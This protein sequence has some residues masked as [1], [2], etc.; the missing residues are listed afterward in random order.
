[1]IQKMW[2]NWLVQRIGTSNWVPYVHYSEVTEFY[3]L[4][5]QTFTGIFLGR[6]GS[7]LSALLK[8]VLL[9]SIIMQIK[10]L[11]IWIVGVKNQLHFGTGLGRTHYHLTSSTLYWAHH[12]PG[13]IVHK[14]S[15]VANYVIFLD[16][17]IWQNFLVM[18][19]HSTNVSRMNI[20][21]YPLK[22]LKYAT[23]DPRP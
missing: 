21:I 15:G 3:V 19:I 7:H 23:R 13:W 2:S 6:T 20:C 14:R 5:M 17:I 1:M 16:H 12:I 18:I 8:L 4:F 10:V 22:S 9:V 11:E